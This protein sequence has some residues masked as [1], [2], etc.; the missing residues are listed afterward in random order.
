MFKK[1]GD[2]L[3]LLSLT[4]LSVYMMTN[5]FSDS[6]SDMPW[7]TIPAGVVMYTCLGLQVLF[8]FKRMENEMY[9]SPKLKEGRKEVYIDGENGESSEA[10][11]LA[12]RLINLRFSD[13]ETVKDIRSIIS[14]ISRIRNKQTYLALALGDKFDPNSLS[15]AKFESVIDNAEKSY[16]QLIASLLTRLESFDLKDFNAALNNKGLDANTLKERTLIFQQHL[17]EIKKVIKGGESLLVKL[18]Q[19]VIEI[20]KLSESETSFIETDGIVDLDNAIQ[21]VQQYKNNFK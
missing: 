9:D 18:D 19:L 16:N 6:V 21:T 2:W 14:I 11:L 4:T 3:F 8:S 17:R 20:T 12:N 7:L 13:Q 10:A 5:V 1:S 15:H